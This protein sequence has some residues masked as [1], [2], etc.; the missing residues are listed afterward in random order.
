MLSSLLP[1][2]RYILR[3]EILYKIEIISSILSSVLLYKKDLRGPSTESALFHFSAELLFM[4]LVTL[5]LS[6]T[7]LISSVFGYLGVLFFS[8]LS[9]QAGRRKEA[10]ASL[11]PLEPMEP[12]EPLEPLEPLEPAKQLKPSSGPVKQKQ[13]QVK[14]A[15][16][17]QRKE[18]KTEQTEQTEQSEAPV[19]PEPPA[20]LEDE[21]IQQYSLNESLDSNFPARDELDP[22][23]LAIETPTKFPV[24]PK[25]PP[26]PSF[27]DYTVLL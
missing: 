4:V 3:R 25:A 15:H 10:A 11:E 1:E 22:A 2:S 7:L 5:S 8:R 20:L 16:K 27:T 21:S 26:K 13:K 19:L 17:K 24:A 9:Q 14:Q 12:M 23:P 18:K 6:S